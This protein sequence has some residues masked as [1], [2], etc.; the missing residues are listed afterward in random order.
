MDASETEKESRSWSS[1]IPAE[2]RGRP[3][4]C[5]NKTGYAGRGF[6]ALSLIAFLALFTQSKQQVNSP[7]SLIPTLSK[8]ISDFICPPLYAQFP[9]PIETYSKTL[10]FL[11]YDPENMAEHLML[12]SG[13]KVTD[14]TG[15]ISAKG[16][17]SIKDI[18]MD[19]SGNV[20]CAAFDTTDTR[21]NWEIIKVTLNGK[22]TPLTNTA[23]LDESSPSMSNDQSRLAYVA[24]GSVYVAGGG[25]KIK[26]FP[27]KLS[28]YIEVRWAP[29]DKLLVTVQE[30]RKSYIAEIDPADPYFV[31]RL[32]YSENKVI[33]HNPVISPDGRNLVYLSEKGGNT[34][35]VIADRYGNSSRI[36]SFGD[37]VIYSDSSTIV[38]S[39][40]FNARPHLFFTTES[41]IELE[42]IIPDK[43][44]NS[45]FFI[46]SIS[47]YTPYLI[48]PKNPEESS[49]E[50]D[51]EGKEAQP[52]GAPNIRKGYRLSKNYPNPFNPVT[53][54]QFEILFS[55][56]VRLEILNIRGQLIR[57]L[58]DELKAPGRYTV[59]FNAGGFS[60]GVYLYKLI[61]G[62]FTQTRKMILMK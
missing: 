54:I 36:L 48:S 34:E 12:S 26:L 21:H 19:G 41:G 37:N 62:E 2:I 7:N 27:K 17:V 28:A 1:D 39:R 35:L 46:H 47:T 53:T 6:A 22:I 40:E 58:V 42:A 30:K 51:L 25:N 16:F 8:F 56:I 32:T 49:I 59:E 45:G 33:L 3:R 11:L 61:A 43:I 29:E 55:K 10:A 13:D 31:D 60:S 9:L 44:N 23:E 38:Y 24:D 20:I 52:A 14:V 4:S 57:T 50:G 5:G 18:C 15:S